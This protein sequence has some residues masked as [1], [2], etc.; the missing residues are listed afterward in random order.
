[1]RTRF[2]LVDA[3]LFG[4]GVL[5]LGLFVYLL[6]ILHPESTATYTLGRETAVERAEAF[7]AEQGYATDGLVPRARL[8]R[9]TR[10]LDSLQASMGRPTAIQMLK[11]DGTDLLPAFYWNVQWQRPSETASVPG[12]RSPTRR[13][14]EVDLTQGGAVW[15]FRN[16][17]SIVP[18]AGVDR[19][20]LRAVVESE[21]APAGDMGEMLMAPPDSALASLLRF[22]LSSEPVLAE[23]LPP[24]EADR[25]RLYAAAET[26]RPQGLSARAA[27]AI[28]REHLSATV[29]G[30]LPLGVVSVE[31]LPERGRSAARVRF[32]NGRD[33]FGHDLVH[34]QRVAATVDVTAAGA[35]LDLD[36]DFNEDLP[37]EAARPD[38][39]PEVRERDGEAEPGGRRV[40]LVFS[41]G[42]GLSAETV[43]RVARIAGYV[44]LGLLLVGVLVRRLGARSLDARAAL[45]DALLAGTMIALATLLTVPAWA[46]DLAGGLSLWALVLLG[47]LF[48]GAGYGLLVF[49]ASAASD[50]LVRKAWPEKIE[51]LSL[52]RQGRFVNQPV[53]RALLRGVA[54]AGVLLGVQVGLL[55]VPAGVL[56]SDLSLLGADATYSPFAASLTNYMWYALALTFGV[57]VGLGSF[58]RRWPWTV[59]PGLALALGVL[60]FIAFD[61][62][63]SPGWLAWAA[64]LALGTVLAL[65]Y[66]RHDALVIIVAVLTAGVLWDTA[67]GWLAAG[68]PALVDAALG[69]ALA[70]GTAAVGVVGVR[71]KRTGE[72]LPRYVP[73][74]V[75]EQRER[76]R[77]TRELEIAREV[78]QSFLPACM[79]EVAGIDLAARCLAAEEVGGDYYDFIPLRDGRLALVIGDVSGKGIQAA[80]FMTLAKGFL[81]TLAHETDRPAEV[82][83]RANRL[84][85]ANAARGTF[86][87]LIYGIFDLE[88]QTF[89]FARAG[90]NP[91]ILKRSPNQTADFV[92]PPGLA[93]GLTARE[94]F[95]DV[96]EEQTIPLRRGDTLVF[97]TDGFSEAMDPAK[98]LYTDE[99]LAD[100]VAGTGPDASAGALLQSLITD[101]L[102]H[103][104]EAPQHDDMTMVVARISTPTDHHASPY[105]LATAAHD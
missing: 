81:Q 33:A 75:T 38:G 3:A 61:L 105:P 24:I 56:S 74:Y 41:S 95:D 79:P 34:G 42:D 17:Q 25:A 66:A 19:T 82:L 46:S 98:T 14:H 29:G 73:D 57:Y 58:L 6:P 47:M 55:L 85:V 2:D 78:Q 99:R 35:L 30:T 84:F 43:R 59:V 91:V 18:R 89:T 60:G 83:R 64:P 16:R 96:I 93:I 52:V 100:A 87:S 36:L 53:G 69:F 77:L 71:S 27:A 92:Q 9:A 4:L 22:D 101:V 11:A 88:A 65:A 102:R 94:V 31:A 103:A 12:V 80:F 86:I 1:M 62:P 23:A 49:V 28:A 20:V 48:G 7:L 70:A 51:T 10:L 72:T 97:Y 67:E 40:Q 37:T 21:A 44:V 26:G 8:R 5:G 50:A 63:T 76:G 104:G 68:S 45:K 15:Q 13:V 54:V 90:H 39:R 32:E